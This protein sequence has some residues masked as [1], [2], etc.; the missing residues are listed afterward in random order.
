MQMN[1]TFLFKYVGKSEWETT[2]ALTFTD[3]LPFRWNCFVRFLL[4]QCDAY[5]HPSHPRRFLHHTSPKPVSYALSRFWSTQCDG[6]CARPPRRSLPRRQSN[7]FRALTC[8]SNVFITVVETIIKTHRACRT[9][10]TLLLHLQTC[11]KN[12]FGF[13][14][15]IILIIYCGDDLLISNRTCN[16]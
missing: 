4:T 12:I 2:S 14:A 9:S 16:P 7:V 1:F 8:P 10:R 3:I 15:E 13:V 11:M 6:F 5:S